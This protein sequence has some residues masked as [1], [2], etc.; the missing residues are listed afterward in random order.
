MF[1]QLLK[2]FRIKRFKH[3]LRHQADQF[4][5]IYRDII[6]QNRQPVDD[7]RLTY[8]ECE[9]YS[10]NAVLSQ[11][12]PCEKDV[13]IDLGSGTAKACIPLLLAYNIR[14]A[15]GIEIDAERHRLAE[16]AKSRSSKAIQSKLELIHG[17]FLKQS[18]AQATIIFINAT[19]FFN[20]HWQEVDCYLTNHAPLYSRVIVA[21][22]TLSSNDFQLVNHLPVAMDYGQAHIS[23]YRRIPNNSATA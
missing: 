20:D 21:S 7:I 15:I 14:Q 1:N 5:H 18:I 13:F 4:E 16:K 19:A 17:D 11:L 6:V 23:I 9:F 2:Q 22:K 12:N 8:G 3:R 10:F